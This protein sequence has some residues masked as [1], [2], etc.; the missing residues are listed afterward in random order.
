[1]GDPV[2]AWRSE[3]V[4]V[5][6]VFE[7]LSGVREIAGDDEEFAGADDLF[8]GGTFFAES[9]EKSA[10]GDVGDLL[11]GMVVAGDDAA[12]FELKASEHS[13]S[14]VDELTGDEGIELFGGEIGP[15]GVER[16]SRHRKRVSRVRKKDICRQRA[17]VLYSDGTGYKN[18]AAT[19]AMGVLRPFRRS[20]RQCSASVPQCSREGAEPQRSSRSK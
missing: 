10:L 7:S 18:C 16:F 8:G 13:L 6:A 3:D 20:V 14:A 15:A 1:M 2:L 11:I 9:E 17:D 5:D 12:L 19:G 4:E